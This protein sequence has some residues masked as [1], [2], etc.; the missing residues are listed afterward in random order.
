LANPAGTGLP[1][2]SIGPTKL[3]SLDHTA[4]AAVSGTANLTATVALHRSARSRTLL[5]YNEL[6][7][8]L[9]TVS[10]FPYDS[11]VVSADGLYSGDNVALAAVNSATVAVYTSEVHNGL[12]AHVDSV[13][14]QGALT[15]A[16]PTS[17]QVTIYVTES[18]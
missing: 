4:W 7:V 16:I 18:F 3:G 10:W 14:V 11:M 5:V 13:I 1:G 12:A 15:S 17:G 9:R 8:D 2:G 6:D